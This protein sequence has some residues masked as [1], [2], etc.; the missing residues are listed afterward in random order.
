MTH[1]FVENPLINSTMVIFLEKKLF[2]KLS[3]ILLFLSKNT[4]S[5]HGGV[6]YYLKYQGEFL[7]QL[8]VWI[9]IQN[10]HNFHLNPILFLL[11]NQV[12]HKWHSTHHAEVSVLGLFDSRGLTSSELNAALFATRNPM[13]NAEKKT[14]MI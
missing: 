3:L 2:I 11:W 9:F 4:T 6:P 8:K 12:W 13:C 7:Y 5:Q 10:I 1:W 14:K